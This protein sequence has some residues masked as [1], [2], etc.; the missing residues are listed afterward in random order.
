MI[1]EGLEL[2]DYFDEEEMDEEFMQMPI[3]VN[4]LAMDFPT[5][6]AERDFFLGNFFSNIRPDNEL[7]LFYALVNHKM[8]IYVNQQGMFMIF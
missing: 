6:H 7:L 4:D 2:F 1:E 8:H 3:T 5:I